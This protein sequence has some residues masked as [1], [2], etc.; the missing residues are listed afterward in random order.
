MTISWSNYRVGNTK[1]KISWKCFYA[2]VISLAPSTHVQKCANVKNRNGIFPS[3][4][5]TFVIISAPSNAIKDVHPTSI[6]NTTGNF[7]EVFF[8]A[9]FHPCVNQLQ[10]HVP[11]RQVPLETPSPLGNSKKGNKSSYSSVVKSLPWNKAKVSK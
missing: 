5:Y 3:F 4:V 10:N 7:P 2:S 11:K 6:R 1:G 9:C 8:P